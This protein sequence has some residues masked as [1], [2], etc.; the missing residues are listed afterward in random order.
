MTAL[1]Q[2]FGFVGQVVLD[3]LGTGFVG[4]VDV[5]A[6]DGTAE[7]GAVGCW[8]ASCTADGV[9]ED[10]DSVSAGS[11]VKSLLASGDQVEYHSLGGS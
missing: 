2:G 9:V 1:Q 10:E 6:L 8:V 11:V 4:L 7:I 3:S 5:H